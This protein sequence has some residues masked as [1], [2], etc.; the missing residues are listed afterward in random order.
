LVLIA[1]LPALGIQAYNEYDLRK[2]REAEIRH[3]VVQI[4]T[5]FGEEMGELREGARQLLVALGQLPAVQMKR[6]ADCSA[7]FANLGS[8]Y[9]SYNLVAAA[10]A[11]GHVF[12]A[13]GP[14][15]FA[16]VTDQPFFQRA[17]LLKGADQVAVGNYWANPTT[18]QK[19]IHFAHPFYDE[20]GQ[21]AG[22]VF[23]GLDLDWLSDHLKDRGL[24][25]SQSILIADREGNIIARLPHPEQLV[26][27][28]MRKSH[29]GIMDGDTTGWEEAAGVDGVTRI[30]G[31]VPAQLPPYDLFLSAGQEKDDAFA[32]IDNASIRGISLIAIGFLLA[33]CTAWWCGRIFVQRPIAR[34][35][36]VAML[37]GEGDYAA[38]VP[39]KDSGSELDRLGVAFNDMADALAMRDAAQK[40]AEE[41]LRRLNATL[42]ERVVQRTEDLA[43]ANRLLKSEIKER[44][45]IQTKL[46]HAQKI[47][48]I[49]QLTSGIAH[50][51]NNLL[52]AILGNLEIARR[53]VKEEK[54][55]NIL[56]TAT[57]AAKR[58]AKLVGDLLAFSRRQRLQLEPVDMNAV[59][60]NAQELVDRAI[61]DNIRVEKN[62][63]RELWRATA[64]AAQAELAVLN[65]SINARDAMPRG[66][67]ITV[68]TAN[69][70]DGDAR[71][72]AE[73]RGDFVMVAVT[74]SGTGMTD[75]VRAKVFE[76]FFTTKPV[77]KGTGL[78]LSMVYGL[79]KQCGGSISIETRIGHGTT[80]AMFF[81]RASADFLAL[82]DG[83]SSAADADIVPQHIGSTIL[84]VD[85]DSEVREFA[86]M[87]LRDLGYNVRDAADPLAALT[88]LGEDSD[89]ALLITDFAMPTMTGVDLI[90]RA[91]IL[92]PGLP[93]ILITGFA[94]MA[95]DD[96]PIADTAI[97]K[98]PFGISNLVAQINRALQS[99][100]T[101]RG[102]EF[103]P[104][105]AVNR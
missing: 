69:V 65:L 67:S 68:S 96:L 18:G 39:R 48:A 23:V 31:Y 32:A 41:K 2:A 93:A 60:D 45:S 37:W 83:V 46:L 25:P 12:C 71:L 27:K 76:P 80:I 40:D 91:R 74:D 29:E 66:G 90:T 88:Q 44:E 89:V 78:G 36:D 57:R 10:D 28:N 85:D 59:I 82:G 7:L 103:E 105:K 19:A 52:T 49:G 38:R 50:D 47:E 100:G 30:F 102:P 34:L 24:T 62:F 75:E 104:A 4:T 86:V 14:T 77:G 26:G 1:V 22:V 8:Q 17:M 13:S 64:E 99:A 53:R 95:A 21:I 42:E 11:S 56:D 6:S 61:G 87:A 97:L 54:T 63:D 70:S 81:P 55:Q 9:K 73:L 84:V 51:F 58:G 72:P 33:I 15:S 35:L 3:Q 20:A 98:K 5:Q 94:N 101:A 79:V 16:A 92:V 43:N